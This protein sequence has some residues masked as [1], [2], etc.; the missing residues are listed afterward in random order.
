M[1]SL[2]HDRDGEGE[3]VGATLERDGDG[4]GEGDAVF[5]GAGAGAAVAF[6]WAPS[7]LGAALGMGLAGLLSPHAASPSTS[8]STATIVTSQIQTR[9]ECADIATPPAPRDLTAVPNVPSLRPE[10][11]WP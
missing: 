10:V 3:G 2:G 8:A 4:V 7:A 9:R 5:D 6:G 1:L 11:L